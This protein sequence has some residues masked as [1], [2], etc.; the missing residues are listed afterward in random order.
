MRWTCLYGINYEL[1]N[2]YMSVMSF[3]SSLCHSEYNQDIVY[4]IIISI[5]NYMLIISTRGWPIHIGL[6]IN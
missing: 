6:I 5:I 1:Q 3:G 4:M 2:I